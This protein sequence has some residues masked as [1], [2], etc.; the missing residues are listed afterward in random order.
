MEIEY[1]G[2]VETGIQLVLNVNRSL[3]EFTVYHVLPNDTI[4]TLEFNN[5]PLIAGDVLTI[6]TVFGSKGA[7]LVRAG[8]SSSVLYGISPQSKYT[9]LQPGGNSIR[10][11]AEGAPVPLTVAY[12]TKY[13][14]L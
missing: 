8:T 6:S 3:P 9:E 14:G 10:V 12:V 11:Y 7:T 13:G 5:H 2:S 4:Q 1:D